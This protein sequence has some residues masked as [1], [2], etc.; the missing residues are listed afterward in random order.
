MFQ[1]GD[2]VTVKI[3]D[4]LGEIVEVST[5]QAVIGKPARATPAYKVRCDS[6]QPPTRWLHES[7]LEPVEK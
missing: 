2:E 5:W 4:C 3:G 6:W 7:D 1:V